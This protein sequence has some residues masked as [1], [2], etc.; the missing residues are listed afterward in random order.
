MQLLSFI[1]NFCKS[2]TECKTLGVSQTLVNR[3]VRMRR[4]VPRVGVVDHERDRE[5][6]CMSHEAPSFLA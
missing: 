2:S 4:W 6:A 3:L 5:L 1:Q